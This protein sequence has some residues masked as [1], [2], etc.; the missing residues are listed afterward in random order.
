MFETWQ[1]AVTAYAK[2][3]RLRAAHRNAEL[4]DQWQRGFT[5][6]GR[7]KP[8]TPRPVFDTFDARDQ[9]SR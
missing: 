3:Y 1:D 5:L 4:P 2:R 6:R 8:W 7:A 9:E